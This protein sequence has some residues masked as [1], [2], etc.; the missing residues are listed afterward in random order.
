MVV[1]V[2][3]IYIDINIDIDNLYVYTNGGCRGKQEETEAF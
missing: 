3:N 1:M 2:G